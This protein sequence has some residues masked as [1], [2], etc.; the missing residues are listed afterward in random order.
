MN[1]PVTAAERSAAAEAFARS[2]VGDLVRA[3]VLRET[4]P[5]SVLDATLGQLQALAAAYGVLAH[6]DLVITRR[7]MTLLNALKLLPPEDAR[8]I[9]D[10][11]R[12]GGLL[13]PDLDGGTS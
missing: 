8:T 1:A 4:A 7:D 6:W 3:G 10:V 11:L 9:V 13:P 5:S 2:S 12:C